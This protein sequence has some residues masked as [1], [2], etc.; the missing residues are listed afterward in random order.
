MRIL[1]SLSAFL[2]FIILTTVQ[3]GLTSCT[4]D[5]T[6]YDTVT[7]VEKDTLTIIQK[8]T[9]IIKDTAVSES[10]LTANHWKILELRGVNEGSVLYYLRGGS[11]N[12]DNYDNEYFVFNADHTGYEVN[13]SGVTFNVPNWQL[14]TEK[15]KLTITYTLSPT[16]SMIITWD[17]L[18]FKNNRVYYD[19]YYSN[20]V[21]GNDFHGQGI[22]IAK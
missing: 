10:I 15:A 3:G 4:K 18:R 17:N 19:E 20:I 5:N 7:V 1:L 13:N 14:D 2:T 12:T 16:T 6:I 22:R 8:D 21:V 11:S 9:I